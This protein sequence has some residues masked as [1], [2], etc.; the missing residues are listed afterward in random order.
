MLM[1]GR[2][3]EFS[4]LREGLSSTGKLRCALVNGKEGIG[5]TFLLE[6]VS[7]SL[8]ESGS[9][10]LL[11]ANGK[12]CAGPQ[13]LLSQFTRNLFSS[14]SLNLSEPLRSFARSIGG[15]FASLRNPALPVNDSDEPVPTFAGIFIHELSH[16]L[17]KNNQ[18]GK[19]LTPVIVIEDINLLTPD[20]LLWLSHDFNHAL[21]NSTWFK[22]CRFLF[23]STD[24]TK[25]YKMFWA[26][27]GIENPVD[28]KLLPFSASE[29]EEFSRSHGFNEVN[30]E[31]L[32]EI[33]N[34]NP[35]I[36][37]KYLQNG[38][39]MNNKNNKMADSKDHKGTDLSKFTEKELEYLLYASYPAKI[40]RYNLE[41][42][43]SPKLS[44]FTYNWL[45]RQHQICDILAD[46]DLV[47]HDSVREQMRAFHADEEPSK[48]EEMVTLASVLD[49]F[50]DLFP[51]TDSHWI[52]INLQA[53]NSFSKSLCKRVFSEF[54]C[55]AILHFLSTHE[56]VF[57]KRGKYFSISDNTRQLIQRYMELSDVE[58]KDGLLDSV[59]IAWEEDQVAMQERRSKIDVE[60]STFKSEIDEIKSQV[61]HFQELKNN[62]EN[63]FKNPKR[64]K[65]K[66]VI[67]FNMSLALVVVG[68]VTLG[69]CLMSD[70]FGAYHAAC[71]LAVTIFG[72]FWPNVEV[73]NV[74]PGGAASAPNLAI[75]TQQRSLEHRINGLLSR[76][77]SIALNLENLSAESKELEQ[78]AIEPYLAEA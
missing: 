39:I 43:C 23:S 1:I 2:K 52:P 11:P 62:I 72:F 22:N 65:P 13:D 46:G 69:I 33:S 25:N 55:E 67:T 76:A 38:F 28:L 24:G 54:E 66:R 17:E 64:S 34:G 75:E 42:F 59:S 7:S 63:S 37:L 51:D 57:E 14:S 32:K 35:A 45:K 27:F 53:L 15:K 58:I 40:N 31:D 18:E 29:M 19:H 4:Y 6:Q 47:L 5:K 9:H 30:A 50:Y 21:R 61:S 20:T 16:L 48:A 36:A 70:M 77:N 44:A 8:L 78:S 12:D 49:A 71:G 41:H 68:L 73:R 3:K 10:I 60:E 56:D 74:N 26:K